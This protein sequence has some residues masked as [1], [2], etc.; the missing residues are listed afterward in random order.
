MY[1]SARKHVAKTNWEKLDRTNGVSYSDAT[2]PEWDNV[3]ESAGLT[4][5]VD[6]ESIYGLDVS[7]NVAYWRKVNSVP[8]A[9]SLVSYPYV[10]SVH[11]P[12]L[13]LMYV[14]NAVPAS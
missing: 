2:F 10:S 3:V 13:Y 5:L 14:H 11:Q 12:S 1:L 9:I 6:R 4:T 8:R 7:V